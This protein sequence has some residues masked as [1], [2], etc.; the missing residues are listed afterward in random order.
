VDLGIT[1]PAVIHV[2]GRGTRDL[3]NG[4]AQRARRRQF[5]A[6]R[7]MLQEAETV[8]AVRRSQG[9]EA[10]WMRD[11]THKRSRQVVTHAQQHRVGTMRL[12]RLAGIC[13][14]TVRRTA[15]TRRGAQ[16]RTN[17]RLI[18]TWP[19]EQLATFIAYQAARVGMAVER[20]D[21]AYAS[22]TCPACDGRAHHGGRP[23]GGVYRLRVQRA[24]GCGGGDHQQP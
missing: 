7:T 23:P 17:N 4:R 16:A 21:P 6:R 19:F 15:R 9:K 1:V 20:V 3:G 11:T 13:Q 8:R 5:A 10:R 18:A 22:R 2:V 14:R 24:P 12:E